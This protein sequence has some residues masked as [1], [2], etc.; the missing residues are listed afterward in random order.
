MK[1][2]SCN[3]NWNSLITLILKYYRN[4]TEKSMNFNFCQV[5]G[6]PKFFFKTNMQKI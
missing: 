3:K 1:F 6:N 4:E 5:L 2:K